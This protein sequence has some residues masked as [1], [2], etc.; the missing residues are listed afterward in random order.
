MIFMGNI[1]IKEFALKEIQ[2]FRTD[3]YDYIIDFIGDINACIE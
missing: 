1:E 3:I 2:S